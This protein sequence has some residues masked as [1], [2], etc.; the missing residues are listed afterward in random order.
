MNGIILRE[1]YMEGNSNNGH[2]FYLLS[3]EH[4]FK[5]FLLNSQNKILY[6]ILRLLQSKASERLSC[7]P[8]AMN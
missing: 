8:K 3:T 4:S 1:K 5:C 7:L 6:V 2:L